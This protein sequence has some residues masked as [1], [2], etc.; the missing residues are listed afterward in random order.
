M[1]VLLWRI[2]RIP[3]RISSCTPYKPWNNYQIENY[4]VKNFTKEI[5]QKWEI[6]TEYYVMRTC[7]YLF[8]VDHA[9]KQ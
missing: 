8:I 9:F 4:F 7:P 6:L 2:S 3:V 1:N 5:N